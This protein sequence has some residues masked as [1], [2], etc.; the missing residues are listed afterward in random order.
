MVIFINSDYKDAFIDELRKITS[1]SSDNEETKG[2][3]YTIRGF[4]VSTHTC[5]F[6]SKE[7]VITKTSCIG[8]RQDQRFCLTGCITHKLLKSGLNGK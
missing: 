1:E 2:I 7:F 3:G 6:L 5:K 8:G 4:S